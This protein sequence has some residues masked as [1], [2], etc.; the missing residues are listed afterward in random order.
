MCVSLEVSKTYSVVTEESAAK[1]DTSD[2]GYC[3]SPMLLR[4]KDALSEVKALGSFE[5]S[6]F[7]SHIDFYGIDE[8]IN[9]QTGE[10]TTYHVRVKAS[11]R[12]LNRFL[13]LT[14]GKT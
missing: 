7:N 3:F 12:A 8:D 4:L 14:K 5:V 6:E 11:R 1:G 2:N 9:Y 10:H 13:K